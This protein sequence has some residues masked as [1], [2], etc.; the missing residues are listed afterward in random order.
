MA[1]SE[2]TEWGMEG[3]KYMLSE[4]LFLFDPAHLLQA[5]EQIGSY[6]TVKTTGYKENNEQKSSLKYKSTKGKSN[7][8]GHFFSL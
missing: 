6:C 8:L 1:G 2:G 4:S 3:F 5:T 7:S